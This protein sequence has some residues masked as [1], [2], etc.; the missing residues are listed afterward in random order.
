[1][2]W[3]VEFTDEFERWW[4]GLAEDEQDSVDQMVRLLQKR[5]PSLGKATRRPYP[6]LTALKYE[7]ATSPARRQA[8]SCSICFR[9]ETLRHFVDGR[10]QDG[11]R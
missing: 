2:E 7:G 10:G 9:S 11:E 6:I 5:G 1:M 8:I 4:N 3:E